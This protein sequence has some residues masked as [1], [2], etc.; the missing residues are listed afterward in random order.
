M[1]YVNKVMMLLAVGAI[2]LQNG[3]CV[4]SPYLEFINTILLGITA[5]ATVWIVQAAS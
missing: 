3:G 5:G 1:K 4:M 2:M